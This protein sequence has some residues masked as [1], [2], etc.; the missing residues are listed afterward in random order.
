MELYLKL[1]TPSNI[2]P[3]YYFQALTQVLLGNRKKLNQSPKNLPPSKTDRD[4]TF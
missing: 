3:N 2:K 4:G 1:K